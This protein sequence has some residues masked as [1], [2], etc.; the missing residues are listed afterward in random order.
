MAKR[1]KGLPKE[2]TTVTT[3]S[4]TVALLM[5]IVLPICGFFIGMHYQAALDAPSQLI[6][7]HQN[8]IQPSLSPTP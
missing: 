2:L 7:V 8:P 4:K 1:Q 5:F 6:P 3:V